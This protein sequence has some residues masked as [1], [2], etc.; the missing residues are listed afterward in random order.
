MPD[1]VY[2]APYNPPLDA[3]IDAAIRALNIL[4]LKHPIARYQASAIDPDEPDDCEA[5]AALA[6]AAA[7]AIDP[8]FEEIARQGAVITDR[9]PFDKIATIA[10]NEDLAVELQMAADECRER[11][12][13]GPDPDAL[14]DAWKDRQMEE[15]EK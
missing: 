3:A 14:Y 6:L 9:D 10:I 15:R 11:Q 1:P 13:A 7:S 4:K 12:N 2:P 5:L 8:L